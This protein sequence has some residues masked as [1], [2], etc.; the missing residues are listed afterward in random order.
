[1]VFHDIAHPSPLPQIS[2]RIASHPSLAI[3]LVRH[4]EPFPLTLA[5][6]SLPP[7]TGC[8]GGCNS[9]DLT[10]AVFGCR[11]LWFHCSLK[12]GRP[13]VPSVCLCQTDENRKNGM[14]PVGQQRAQSTRHL[15]RLACPNFLSEPPARAHTHSSAQS[16]RFQASVALIIRLRVSAAS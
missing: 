7:R 14:Q 9:I 8:I 6:I 1:M 2:P 15:R 3:T 5:K 13:T 16:E 10:C 4:V 11:K 12:R